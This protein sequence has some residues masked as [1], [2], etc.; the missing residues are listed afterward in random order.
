MEF[1]GDGFKTLPDMIIIHASWQPLISKHSAAF[2]RISWYEKTYRKIRIIHIPV[3]FKD[4]ANLS[5]IFFTTSVVK[6]ALQ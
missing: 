6:E 3:F 5:G 2:P 4:S 1:E